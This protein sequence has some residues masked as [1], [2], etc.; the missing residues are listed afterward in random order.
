M[1]N[2]SRLAF[3]IHMDQPYKINKK[4]KE[5]LY[6]CFYIPSSEGRK[7]KKVNYALNNFQLLFLNAALLPANTYFTQAAQRIQAA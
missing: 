4:I 1:R 2:Q 5:F 6:N 7:K 3:Q